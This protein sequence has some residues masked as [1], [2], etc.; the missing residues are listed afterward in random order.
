MYS[1][2][3]LSPSSNGG[4]FLGFNRYA[5][6]FTKLPISASTQ[7]NPYSK[8]H[9]GKLKPHILLVEDDPVAQ[10]IN[11]LFLNQ[12]GCEVAVAST[13]SEAFEKYNNTID[14]ILLD[15]GLP[16]ISGTSVCKQIRT[17]PSGHNVPIIALTAHGGEIKEECLAVG[18]N[19]VAV[20]PI[21]IQELFYLLQRWLNTQK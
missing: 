16:D 18:I 21:L 15:I 5:T 12:F 14:L 20:K 9:F 7:D 19:E 1:A 11:V 17:L 13:G 10:K 8:L 4:P 2:S 3:D 6:Q